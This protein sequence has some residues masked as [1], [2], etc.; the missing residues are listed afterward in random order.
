MLNIFCLICICLNSTLYSSS[1]FFAKLP[2]AYAF[3]N[4]II[5]VMPIIPVLF[6]LLA[7]V[8]QAA[9]SFR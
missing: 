7:F 2:E 1:F 8:W 4:P 6:F 5:D 9:V 3:F